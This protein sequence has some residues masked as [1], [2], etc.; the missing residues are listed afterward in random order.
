M[1]DKITLIDGSV[2]TLNEGTIICPCC[3][4]G[5]MRITSAN[6]EDIIFECHDCRSELKIPFVSVADK[7]GEIE[8]YPSTDD[9]DTDFGI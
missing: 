9:D 2:M 4:N 5:S 3:S 6:E 7:Y 8:Y 1:I